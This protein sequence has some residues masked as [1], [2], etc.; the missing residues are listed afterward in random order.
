MSTN[1]DRTCMYN[2]FTTDGYHDKYFEIKLDEFLD[3]AYSII[4]NVDTRNIN[5]EVELYIK[6]PC[7]K[8]KVQPYRTRDE[9]K[10]H[11]LQKG[12][13]HGYTTWWE[14][15]ETKDTF[16][17]VEQC[18][19]ANAMEND[20]VDAA[21][22]MELDNI[23]P[24]NNNLGSSSEEEEEVPGEKKYQTSLP[25]DLN[26]LV[27]ALNV[28][29]RDVK[30]MLP[31]DNKLVDNFYKAK[32]CSKE[33]SL[34][35]KKIHSCKKHCM[36]FYDINY[37]LTHSRWYGT[38]RYKSVGR[39]VPNLVLT[40]MPIANKL[41]MLYMS[42]KT[43]KDM[44]W[45]A[46]HKTV[47]GSMV[48]PSDGRA[49]KHFDLEDPLFAHETRN[50]RLGLCTDDFSP[51][52]S[53]SNPYMCWPVF[54]SV[55]NLPPWMALKESYVQLALLIPG[56]KTPGHNIDVFLRPLID[57]LKEL[58]DVGI[59]TYDAYRRQNFTMKAI[60]LWTVS[61]FSRI[62][63]VVRR[64]KKGFHAKNTVLSTPPPE[65]NGFEIWQQ[66][67]AFPTVYE[68]TPYDPKDKKFLV[69][70][71][72][73]DVMHIKKNVFENIFNTVMNTPK[74]KDNIK[75]RM[76]IKK[77]CNRPDLHVWNQNSKVLKTKASYTLSKR[78]VK[79]FYTLVH[80]DDRVT[81][82][83][84]VCVKGSCYNE[85]ESDYY[86][87][88][89]EVIEVDYHSMLGTYMVV[90]FKCRWFDPVQGVKVNVKHKLVDVKYRLRGCI[91]N[92]FILAHQAQQAYYATYPSMMKYL[93]DWWAVVKAI[94]RGIFQ[95][96]EGI[97]ATE[98][99]ANDNVDGEDFF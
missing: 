71:H 73:L 30:S 74:T 72:N 39:K 33:I 22:H 42:E 26:I 87:E 31:K 28:I 8:C 63:I 45:Y 89:E 25:R 92:P 24:T 81:K 62:C 17:H 3:F 95:L 67:Y 90:M 85:D 91:Y 48:H 44:T 96:A 27:E 6:C 21:T 40:Y 68:G 93:K 50:V 79:K 14:Q 75:A 47:D 10:Y 43:T 66:V 86:E 65:L 82:N 59:N 76:D 13:M 29:V 55:Y 64:D 18:S 56:R 9:V 20:D 46:D 61:D 11:L 35:I 12:F 32:K 41:Q 69:L 88:L 19:N 78:Q 99:S 77:Y 5:G 37:S 4:A 60:L 57:E 1:S 53:F 7:V 34:P 15:G 51:T 16:Q 84:G 70:G 2:R 97:L 38:S 49:C 23:Y 83:S 52:S 80:G 94:P 54:I 98:I 36:L 58:Y